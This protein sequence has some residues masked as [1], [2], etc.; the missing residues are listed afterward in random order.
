MPASQNFVMAKGRNA[1][2][3]IT[4]KRFVKIDPTDTTGQTV[5]QCDT[6]GE[7]AYGVSLFGVTLAEIDKGKGASV[8][9]DGRAIVEQGA[10][11]AVG[12]LVATDNQGRAVAAA[13]GNNILGMVDE[14]TNSGAGNECGVDLSKGGGVA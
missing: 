6:A 8:M 14:L 13:A 2:G 12:D 10:A 1:G 4:K 11:L 9:T 3:A 5:I 7:G